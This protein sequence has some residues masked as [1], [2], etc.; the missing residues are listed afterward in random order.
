MKNR[1]P[2]KVQQGFA[3][4]CRSENRKGRGSL[5]PRACAVPLPPGS[6]HLREEGTP[7]FSHRMRFRLETVDDLR[8]VG[9][10]DTGTQFFVSCHYFGAFGAHAYYFSTVLN[11]ATLYSRP[12]G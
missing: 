12:A 4:R 3:V 7:L 1:V 6:M 9:P 10:G 8:S 5:A 2:V 11:L